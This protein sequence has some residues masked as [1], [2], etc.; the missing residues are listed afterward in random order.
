MQL[1]ANARRLQAQNRYKGPQ[2]KTLQKHPTHPTQANA[3]QRSSL[4]NCWRRVVECAG[5]SKKFSAMSP[6]EPPPETKVGH[7][8]PL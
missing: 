2:E 1:Y 3:L 7:G 4:D 8:A 6:K 5:T